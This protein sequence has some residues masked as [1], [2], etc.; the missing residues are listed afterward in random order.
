MIRRS[1]SATRPHSN[2]FLVCGIL[3]CGLLLITGCKKSPQE[4]Q[5]QLFDAVKHHDVQK[6]QALIQEGANVKQ[7]EADGGWSTL[8]YAARVGDVEMVQLLMKA[9]AD[10]N[11]YGEA[12]G[13]TGSTR[14]NTKPVVLAGATLQLARVVQSNSSIH[15]DPPDFDAALRQPDAVAKLEKTIEILS[16]A[17]K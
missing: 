11:Y 16:A 15:F 4:L 17:P 10:P 3:V 7:P 9:G 14:I 2:N 5:S 13:Q 6:V 12:G 1:A 8:H